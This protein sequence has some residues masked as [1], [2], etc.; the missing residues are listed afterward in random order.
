M[1]YC[2][3][4]F[5]RV[6]T[7]NLKQNSRIL[8]AP[9]QLMYVLSKSTETSKFQAHSYSMNKSRKK[10]REHAVSVGQRRELVAVRKVKVAPP[11]DKLV[12]RQAVQV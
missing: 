5:A 1:K 2:K 8:S 10:I 3:K 7:E 4:I 11:M 6:L 12:L 9:C